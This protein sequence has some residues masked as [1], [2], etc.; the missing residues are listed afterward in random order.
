MKMKGLSKPTV[1]CLTYR[2][3]LCRVADMQ[4][5]HSALV[6]PLWGQ[7]GGTWRVAVTGHHWCFPEIV[8]FSSSLSLPS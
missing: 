3:P 5:E 6:L 7:A 1:G 8:V 4:K 2:R